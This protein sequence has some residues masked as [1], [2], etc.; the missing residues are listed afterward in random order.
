MSKPLRLPRELAFPLHDYLQTHGY[1][2]VES[3]P[4]KS[5]FMLK[6]SRGAFV[7]AEGNREANGREIVDGIMA[8]AKAGDLAAVEWLEARGVVE[9]P[10]KDSD[11]ADPEDSIVRG[12]TI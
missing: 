9:L 2:D 8:K 1:P 5:G 7:V 3:E 6:L 11:P 4:H 12:P 10:T